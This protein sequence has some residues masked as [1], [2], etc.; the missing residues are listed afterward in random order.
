MTTEKQYEVNFFKP[1]S[2]HARANKRLILSL[3]IIWA[4]GVFGFQF[5]LILLN[6]PTP[7]KNYPIFQSSWSQ[8]VQNEAA[9]N[10]VKQDLANVLLAV[11]GK[12]IALKDEHRDVLKNVLSWTVYSMQSESDKSFFIKEPSETSIEMAASSIGL[13][14]T[15]FDKIKR[16]LLP[17]SLVRVKQ[18]QI[19]E[20]CRTALP[21]IMKLY[22]VHNQSFLTDFKFLGFPFHYWY[23]AQFLL[24]MFV[25]LCIFYAKTIDHFNLKHNFIEET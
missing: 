10:E 3:A 22:L 4:V 5:L 7:E 21:E 2:D 11:L 8:V 19:C 18:D 20:N 15:G 1:L 16:D 17:S 13:G 6:K 14:T 23:T 12:N 9:A 25:L 24:I